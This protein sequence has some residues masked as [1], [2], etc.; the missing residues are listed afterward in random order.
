M[1]RHKRFFDRFFTIGS[2]TK[3]FAHR[4]LLLNIE[5]DKDGRFNFTLSATS[6][7]EGKSNLLNNPV[8]VSR[9]NSFI[10]D[11]ENIKDIADIINV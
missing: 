11:I 10:K 5:L 7:I 8:F 1:Y 9:I 6:L 2:A 3:D 4:S